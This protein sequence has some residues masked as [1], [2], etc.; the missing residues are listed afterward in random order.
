[1]CSN[2]SN[3]SLQQKWLATI[4]TEWF[5]CMAQKTVTPNCVQ[6]YVNTIA[7]L[8][9]NLLE[10]VINLQDEKVCNIRDTNVNFCI[11][12]QLAFVSY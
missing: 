6:L 7:R 3:L 9:Q 12:P 11:H 8:S 10:V 1:M 4:R 2:V 5:V